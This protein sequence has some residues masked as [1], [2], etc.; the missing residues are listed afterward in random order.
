MKRTKKRLLGCLI[1]STIVIGSP[2]R[3]YGEVSR[4]KLTAET[5]RLISEGKIRLETNRVDSLLYGKAPLDPDADT[6][7]DGLLNADEIYLYTKEGKTYYNYHSHP[8]LSDT[9]GDG[10]TDK[11]DQEPLKWNV[12]TRDMVMFMELV[13]RED[14]YIREVLNPTTPLTNLYENRLEYSMMHNELAPYWKVK[15]IYHQSNGFDAVLF[16]NRSPYPFLPDNVVQ[17]LGVRGTKG[18]NDVDD[19]TAIFLALNPG[20][21]NTMSEVVNELEKDKLATNLYATGHSLGGYLAQRGVIDANSKGYEW[22][23][24]TYTFNAPKIKGGL[25]TGWLKDIAR[26]GDQLTKEG[27]AIHYKVSND[28]LIKMVGNFEGSVD[29][30]ST[31]NGHGSRSYFESKLNGQLDFSVGKRHDINGTGYVDDKLKDLHFNTTLTDADVYTI[32]VSAEELVD[33][34]VINLLDNITNRDS[35][36]A[37]IQVEDQTDY[38]TMDLSQNGTYQGKLTVTFGDQS[39]KEVTVPIHVTSSS[40][41]EDDGAYTAQL[42]EATEKVER[43][44]EALEVAKQPKVADA[45]ELTILENT[46]KEAE[47][48]VATAKANQDDLIKAIRAF[49][50]ANRDLQA[51][52]AGTDEAKKQEA[53]AKFD[54]ALRT[55]SEVSSRVKAEHLPQAQEAL[56][57]AK[58]TLK[59]RQAGQQVD[60]IAEAEKM[61]AQ[62]EQALATL[63]ASAP[64][65]KE[66]YQVRVSPI[67]K[68]VG[69]IV[70]K[71]EIVNAVTSTA[72][73]DKVA[74]KAV[75]NT[76]LH[77]LPLTVQE[78]YHTIPV[79]VVYADGSITEVT[80]KVTG[81]PALLTEHRHAVDDNPKRLKEWYQVSVSPLTKKVGETVTMHEV[82]QA[83][84]T[85]ASA[86]Q[87]KMKAVVNTYLKQFPFT[88]QEGYYTIPVQVVYQ[89]GSITQV[90]VVVT[91]E[92]EPNTKPEPNENAEA[93]K[94]EALAKAK[95]MMLQAFK[96][97]PLSDEDKVAIQRAQTVEELVALNDK[98]LARFNTQAAEGPKAKDEKADDTPRPNPS[99]PSEPSEEQAKTEETTSSEQSASS[100]T[101]RSEQSVTTVKSSTELTLEVNSTAEKP[102]TEKKGKTLPNTGVK[103]QTV[104]SVVGACFLVVANVLIGITKQ[105]NNA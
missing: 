38:T 96:D 78:G 70:T 12:S 24:R 49:E 47:T 75:V 100:T 18:S 15:K 80:V 41:T 76:Y 27:K 62:A 29:I 14:D 85:T 83:V 94:A 87:V 65:M 7:G 97:Y 3:V 16:E 40:R 20:Q 105:K 48:A 1:I 35:L 69:E 68:Q 6:D 42:A 54:A 37:D 63:K 92:P 23:K 36:P 9:D 31:A 101:A 98:L 67:T 53:Q 34:G 89:D 33:T 56:K 102:A 43:A 66:Q 46:V 17:V 86:D 44:K 74:N 39:V 32:T 64:K 28:S 77:R 2:Y 73:A 95:A 8:L 19:D 21:A 60:K 90:N 71:Q 4:M 58:D 59:A 50:Q 30:G 11:E 104:L 82:V 91:S 61:L 26:K 22:F 81:V 51:A 93:L 103:K 55:Q 5:A 13:Y 88:V 52:K 99:K 57:K 25:F 45:F 72:S 84:T 79:Q 10:I